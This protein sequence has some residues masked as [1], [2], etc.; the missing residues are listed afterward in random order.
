MNSCILIII[1]LLHLANVLA[2]TKDVLCVRKIV[3]QHQLTNPRVLQKEQITAPLPHLTSFLFLD[4]YC[5][6]YNRFVVLVCIYLL[7]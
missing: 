6:M 2:T 3:C 4:E 5:F 1:L 7:Y